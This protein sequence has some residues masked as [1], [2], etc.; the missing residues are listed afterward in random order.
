[1]AGVGGNLGD[2]P[3]IDLTAAVAAPP[4]VAAQ[5][6]SEYMRAWFIRVKSGDAGVLP[7]VAALVAVTIVFEIF[8]P[9]H[10]FLKPVN[11]INL[12]DQSAV[13]IVLG[14]AEIFVLLLGEIDLSIGYVAAIGGI[15]AALLVQPSTPGHMDYFHNWPWY[16]AIAVALLVCA[17]IGALQGLI[18]TRLRLPSFVVTLAG[19]MVWFGVMIIIL[20][21]AGSV[22][23]QS[24]SVVPAEAVIYGIVWDFL[25]PEVAWIGLAVV[26]LLVCGSIWL[27]D[28][29]R[30]RSGL[31]APP[32]GLTIAKI[33]FLVVVGVV[34]VFIC[35]L[36]RGTFSVI[37]GVP[38]VLPLVLGVVGGATLLLE[39]TQFGRHMYAVGGNPE[40]ARR[41]GVGVNTIRTWAFIIAGVVS[42]LG[43][44][45][46][47]SSLGNITT[48]I[49]GGQYVLFAVAAA[50]IGGTSLMGGRGRAI[51]GL[52]GGLTIGAIYNGLYL[53]AFPVEYQYIATGLVLLAAVAV[54][55]L[56]RRSATS[57]SMARV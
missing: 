14:V 9:N 48:N 6:L 28:S 53:L 2:Q 18:I 41:A 51:H 16:G 1:M 22:S 56:S 8:S 55:A 30:R 11:L 33:S 25:S 23:V 21:S 54:D 4:P 15:V 7:V 36:N 38:W 50:V 34:V 45:I 17:G 40:A 43:G 35:G 24:G 31:V 29:S 49:N 20:G 12:F 46:Y 26:L 32:V 44:I 5:T 52:L 27:R 57:G 3:E 19:Q 37:S 39:R 47:C 10:V 13:F 42:G